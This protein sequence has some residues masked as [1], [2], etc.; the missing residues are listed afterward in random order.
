MP[1]ESIQI[2]TNR[3]APEGS[4]AI[5]MYDTG[6]SGPLTLGQLVQAV[7]LRAAA[8]SENQGVLKMNQIT[9]G[10]AKL[11]D[12][13]ECLSSIVDG[14]ASWATA[15]AFLTRTMGI[16]PS[17]LPPNFNDDARGSSYNKRLQAADALKKK[18]DS[19]VQTQQERMI[20][21]QTLVNR[22]DVAH[23]TAA[24]VVRALANSASANA[25]NF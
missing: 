16:S 13:A 18:M 5:A 11:K 23:S 15:K 22:R 1:I 19:L 17:A 8:A 21:L 6:A 9:D 20:D 2:A 24:N 14:S 7:C 4:E 10:S 12:A 3:Y 25:A